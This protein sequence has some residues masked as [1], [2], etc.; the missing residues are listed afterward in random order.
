M[1]FK[2]TIAKKL[3]LGFGILT[4][5]V[6][7]NTILTYN[8]L[9]K[10]RKASDDVIKT[11]SPSVSYLNDLYSLIS[12]SKMLIKNW[13]YI[14]KTGDETPTKIELKNLH[15]NDFPRTSRML[16]ILSERWNKKHLEDYEIIYKTIKDSLFK[17]HKIIMGNLNSFDDYND[18]QN[19]FQTTFLVEEGS[20]NFRLTEKTLKMLNQLI[21]EQEQIVEKAML[22]MEKSFNNFQNLVFIMGILLV[23]CAIIT[24]IFTTNSLVKPINSLKNIIIE[25]GMGVLPSEQIKTGGDEIGDMAY[26]VNSL[27]D[28]LKE[29]SKF[30]LE[31]GN[32][33]FHS[34]FTPLSKKD[35]LGNALLIARDNLKKAQE[36]EKQRQKEDEERNWAT[37]GLAKFSELLRYN[38]DNINNLSENL[39]SHIVKY[40]GANQGGIF[41]MND[42]NA[43]KFIELTACYAYERHKY[44]EKKINIGVGLVGRCVKEN[45]TIYMTD[46]PQNYI[47]ITSGLGEAPP[48]SLLLVPLNVNEIT[49]G[50]IELASF[51]EFA[52]YQI[53]FLEK[54]GES[55]ASTISS[56]KINMKTAT[57][58]KES[59]EQSEKL[60][61]QEEEVRQNMEE[62]QATQEEAERKEAQ[63]IS[64]LDAVDKSILKAELSLDAHIIEVNHKYVSTLSYKQAELIGKNIKTFISNDELPRFD[65]LWKKV[66]TGHI[67]NVVAYRKTKMGE[68][69]QLFISYTPVKD[70]TTKEI[71]KVLFLAHDISNIKISK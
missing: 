60:A 42:D 62:M 11:Y 51:Q 35:I 66:L 3:G 10:S 38:N 5:A 4:V 69:K 6:L 33:N 18:T 43:D 26:A 24:A 56:V 65:N 46:I 34:Q 58:L 71:T 40:M 54:V 9:D 53:E 39:I 47:N 2:I 41:I 15:R 37:R 8:T 29:I 36:D 45:E 44:K 27:V 68:L 57:L 64:I 21:E 23:L 19:L 55:I 49:F 14:E 70:K 28:G 25:M 67:E 52:P 30:S 50:I 17:E 20:E 7:L 13:V 59:Q 63:T 32:G 31:I 1:R 48:T 22:S 16:F 12:D 61:Q